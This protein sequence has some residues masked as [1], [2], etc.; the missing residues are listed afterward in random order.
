MFL[1]VLPCTS[2]AALACLALPAQALVN[3][4]ATDRF[5]AVGEVAGMSGVLIADGWVLTASHVVGAV[6]TGSTLFVSDAGQAVIDAVVVH[7]G[8]SFPGNDLALLH[9][10]SP[11]QAVAAPVLYDIE[12]SDLSASGAVTLTSAQNQ[13]LAPNGY[14]YGDLSGSLPTYTQ[15]GLTFTNGVP[16]M[17]TTTYDTHWLVSSGPAYVQSGDSGAGLFMGQVQDS[18]GSTLL[19]IASAQLNSNGSYHSAWVQVASYKTW[20]DSTLASTGQT[21]LWY[22]S[23]PDAP[24]LALLLCGLPGLLRWRRR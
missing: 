13:T 8:A 16:A 3:G 23:V 7:P 21:A 1:R 15:T 10:A 24:A 20:I 17:S 5:D 6:T 19:G 18:A 14:A 12:L 22:S 11:L 4:N 9:L 2:L